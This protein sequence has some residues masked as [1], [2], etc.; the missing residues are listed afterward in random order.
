MNLEPIDRHEMALMVE[1][2]SSI[3]PLNNSEF[4]LG[5]HTALMYIKKYIMG[6]NPFEVTVN[7]KTLKIERA[8]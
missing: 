7:A 5:Y 8:Q 1:E 6:G 4:S 3:V 2:I